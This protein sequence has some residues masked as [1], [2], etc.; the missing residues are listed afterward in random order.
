MLGIY[1]REALKSTVCNA[2]LWKDKSDEADQYPSEPFL[3]K[4]G[5]SGN[6][7]EISEDEKQ[8]AV[9]LFFAQEKARRVNWKRT[10]SKSN[11]QVSNGNK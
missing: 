10:H 7:N 11:Q 9:D 2:I 4:S 5:L 1:F 8:K 6:R 3:W